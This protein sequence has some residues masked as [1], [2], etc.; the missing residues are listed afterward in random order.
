VTT[1]LR[2]DLRQAGWHQAWV[3]QPFGL[4]GAIYLTTFDDEDAIEVWIP[5]EAAS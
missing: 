3:T 1:D 2:D 5:P 4:S